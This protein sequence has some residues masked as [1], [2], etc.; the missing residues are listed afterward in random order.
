MNNLEK[1]ERVKIKKSNDFNIV[2]IFDCGQCFRWG[3]YTDDSYI[4]IV[5][6]KVLI[7]KESKDEI[8]FININNN[9]FESI[10]RDYFDLNRNYASIKETLRKDHV[11]NTAIDFGEGIR[12]LNQDLFECIIS[13]ILSANNRIPMIKRSVNSLSKSFGTEISFNKDKYYSFPSLSQLVNCTVA[14]FEKCGAGFRAKYLI[15][16]IEM[17][18]RREIKIDELKTMS[19]VDARDELMKIPGIGPKI[20]DC[21]LLFSLGRHEVFPTDI[22]VKRVMEHFYSPNNKLKICEIHDM[23]QR[24]FGDYA[25]FAQQYLFYYAREL[26]IG[27]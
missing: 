6:D 13:F 21:I 11:L 5:K 8:E 16:A 18:Y 15:K 14:D 7:V 22:W 20:S 17:I 26:K 10:F 25:G 19:T 23:S 3:R 1:Y 9:E 27:K 4:G 24:L 2:H 12:I